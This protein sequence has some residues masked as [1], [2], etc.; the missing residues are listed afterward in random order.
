M[1]QPQ[2]GP[3][4]LT[5]KVR[6]DT[7]AVDGVR[8][9]A[10]FHILVGHIFLYSNMKELAELEPRDP[11]KEVSFPR[12]FPESSACPE[13]WARLEEMC[14]GIPGCNKEGGD[15]LSLSW[16]EA[17][18]FCGRLVP[19]GH[20]MSFAG[21]HP[22]DA[23]QKVHDVVTGL[24]PIANESD[25][26]YSDLVWWVGLKDI[27]EGWRWSSGEVTNEHAGIPWALR[28]PN[29]SR[30]R[31]E[32]CAGAGVTGHFR[33]FYCDEEKRFLCQVR[34]KLANCPAP[35]LQ[36]SVEGWSI[37]AFWP[38]SPQGSAEESQNEACDPGSTVALMGGG[39]MGLFYIIS[40]FVMV[41]GYCQV[42]LQPCWRCSGG[43]E[44]MPKL[45]ACHFWYRRL[46][47]LAPTYYLTNAIGVGGIVKSPG[48]WNTSLCRLGS[49]LPWALPPG[50]RRSP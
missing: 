19:G 24:W 28:E 44:E 1:S 9:F 8:G 48:A 22:A 3:K 30:G 26:S 46:S 14:Y 11:V 31:G 20:L 50:Y 40:G 6:I 10:V 7:R 34:A 15:D 39:S 38:C 37:G 33:D 21:G 23:K 49:S 42:M 18:Q 12:V 4:L 36:R 5:R 2:D 32:R 13:G 47:R 16:H 25:K 29:I 45:S 17:E 43:E 27:E 41:V 35:C